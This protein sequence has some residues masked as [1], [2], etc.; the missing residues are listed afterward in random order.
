MGS[1]KVR[2]EEER[3]VRREE[4]GEGHFYEEPLVKFEVR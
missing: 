1:R 3:K 2:K 4:A